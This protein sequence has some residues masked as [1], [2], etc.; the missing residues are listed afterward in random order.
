MIT[1]GKFLCSFINFFFRKCME[2]HLYVVCRD[3]GL[4]KGVT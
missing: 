2:I 1:K 3:W 4:I